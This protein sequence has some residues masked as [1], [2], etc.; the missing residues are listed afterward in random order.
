LVNG[1]VSLGVSAASLGHLSRVWPLMLRCRG[2]NPRPFPGEAAV[3]KVKR[4]LLELRPLHTQNAV[5]IVAVIL[6][7]IHDQCALSPDCLLT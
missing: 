3:F 7:V 4:N 5:E 6:V 1:T 2:G